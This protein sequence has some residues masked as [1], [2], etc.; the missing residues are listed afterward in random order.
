MWQHDDPRMLYFPLYF[1]WTP[2]STGVCRIT[3]GIVSRQLSTS[4][5]LFMQTKY[6]G[7]V[8]MLIRGY[9]HERE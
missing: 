3:H 2:S 5:G 6:Y 4:E 8:L 1:R 7:N 9:F